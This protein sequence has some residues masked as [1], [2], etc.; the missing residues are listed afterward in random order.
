MSS[1]DDEILAF[2]GSVSVLCLCLG[3][4]NFTCHQIVNKLGGSSRNFPHFPVHLQFQQKTPPTKKINDI[5]NPRTHCYIGDTDTVAT[6]R[7]HARPP[8]GLARPQCGHCMRSEVD[9]Q[10]TVLLR[11]HLSLPT[12]YHLCPYSS[13]WISKE[14]EQNNMYFG[15]LEVG[16][17]SS[18]KE[19]ALLVQHIPCIRK[20]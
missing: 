16:L 8:A 13:Q 19:R 6:P 7:V 10:T 11:H 4:G 20:I 18:N 3:R 17:Q 15:F 9:Q 12:M 5:Q 14:L 2:N 1:L